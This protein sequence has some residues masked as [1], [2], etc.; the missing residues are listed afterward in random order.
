MGEERR[1]ASQRAKEIDHGG[2]AGGAGRGSKYPLV[3]KNP[4]LGI[5]SLEGVGWSEISF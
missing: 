5:K 4:P 1:C 2:R 3:D